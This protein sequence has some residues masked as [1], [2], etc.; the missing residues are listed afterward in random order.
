MPGCE[1]VNIFNPM[2][3]KILNNDRLIIMAGIAVVSLISWM[4]MAKMSVATGSMIS[5]HAAH[6]WNVHDLLSHF[7]MWVIMMTAMMLPTAGPMILTFSFISRERKQKQQP[8]VKTS[9]FVM[10]YLM[11]TVGYSFLATLLQWGLHNLGFLTS[12]GASS[13][14]LLSGILLLAAG[15][16]QWSNIKHAC[17]R[18]CRNPFNFLMANWK[19]GTTGAMHMGSKH[20]LLC[21][22]CCW[23]LML[24]MLVG[25]VMNLLWMIVITAVI[26]IEKVAPRGDMF[27]RIAGVFMGATGIYFIISTF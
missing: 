13:S 23:A 24:L 3:G 1:S 19:E 22:G 5:V 10:G 20:G 17:L 8:Y 12:A 21:T 16:F 14:Y 4:Y 27:A 6:L 15:T 25:G 18:F 7:M 9:V 26:L 11:V 2:L